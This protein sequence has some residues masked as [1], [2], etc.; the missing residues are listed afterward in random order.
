MFRL[1]KNLQRKDQEKNNTIPCLLRT[2]VRTYVCKNIPCSTSTAISSLRPVLAT[3]RT[4]D[5]D[6][7][8]AR[9]ETVPKEIQA[10]AVRQRAANA[11]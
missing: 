6:T 7:K 8:G 2:Y 4:N 10:I 1:T 11:G 3:R 9:L 5:L